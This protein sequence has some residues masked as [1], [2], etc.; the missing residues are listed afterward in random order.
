MAA[1]T[2]KKK[3]LKLANTRLIEAELYNYTNNKAFLKNMEESNQRYQE[4]MGTDP[5]Y[6]GFVS[7]TV[8]LEV[9]RRIAAVDRLLEILKNSEEDKKIEL[10]QMKYFD[11]SYTDEGIAKKLYVD[12]STVYRWRREI[13]TML[14]EMLGMIMEA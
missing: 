13:I 5:A 14:G 12:K 2:Y 3:F 6:Q 8:I 1:Y 7:T 10:I 4:W 9:S 11:C